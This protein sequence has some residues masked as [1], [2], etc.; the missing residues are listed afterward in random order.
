MLALMILAGGA[1]MLTQNVLVAIAVAPLVLGAFFYSQLGG[2]LPR[3][4]G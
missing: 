1:A 3:D 4:D 2:K